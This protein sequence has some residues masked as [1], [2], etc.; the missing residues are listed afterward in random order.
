MQHPCDPLDRDVTGRT[1]DVRAGSG[2]LPFGGT[3]E[4]AVELL[5]EDILPRVEPSALSS[6]RLRKQLH[7]KSSTRMCGHGLPF[8]DRVWN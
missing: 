6:W 5:V 3:L 7:F 2:H 1:L 8:F 4:I